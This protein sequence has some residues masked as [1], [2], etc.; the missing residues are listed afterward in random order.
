[1]TFRFKTAACALAL[2]SVALGAC[3][4][5]NTEPTAS[6]ED[7]QAL[8][9]PRKAE[10]VLSAAYNQLQAFY[11]LAVI[12]ND[13]NADNARH[14]GSFPTWLEIDTYNYTPAN[15]DIQ[16]QWGGPYN[17]INI[18]NNIIAEVPNLATTTTF[19]EARRNEIVG[20][21]RV[22]R[23]FA[24]HHLVRYFGDVPLVLEPTRAVDPAKIYPARATTAEVYT[25]IVADLTA[26]EGLLGATNKTFG[27]VDGWA[28]KALL[29]RVYLYQQN[30]AQAEAKAS[31]VIGGPFSL[32]PLATLYDGTGGG[33]EMI[34]GLQYST[35]DVENMSFFAYPNGGGGRFE[36]APTPEILAA[37]APADARR[38]Y[39]IRR[40][41]T[42]DV[43][44]KYFR[45]T[46]D[47]D[48]HYVVRLAEMLLTRAEAR[49]QQG[50]AGDART[51]LNAVRT[52]ASLPDVDATLAGPA[53]LDA[54]LAER[55]LELAFEGHRW[56]DLKRTG[57]AVATLGLPSAD[58]QLWPIPQRERNVNPNLSQNPGY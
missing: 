57:R 29:A 35:T 17:L 5:L 21:A 27:F 33:T 2:G 20:E 32:A 43:V 50:K 34:W 30:W 24:Y 38:A 41:G 16:G 49:A 25:Q 36:Y 19:T 18:T 26:A 1:M 11:D 58:R 37:F 47:D 9:T 51:D 15:V 7:T 42:T 10:L 8:N 48:P 28:A 6:V 23:A 4:V 22:L 53:L 54:I 45:V 14:S 39:N 46:T 31:E 55:R 40:V 13:L 3:D 44:G 56:F 52:R 12:Y